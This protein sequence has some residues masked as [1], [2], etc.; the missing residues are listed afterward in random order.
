MDQNSRA[1]R[2][3]LTH[4]QWGPTS[5]ES[6]EIALLEASPQL[7][8]PETT[9]PKRFTHEELTVVLRLLRKNRAPGLDQLKAEA[10]LLLDYLGE[11]VLLDLLNNC[12]ST[13]TVPE[14]WKQALVVNIYKGK[15]SES[16]PANYRPISLLNVLYKIYASLLQKRLATA[17]DH[18]LRSSQFGFRTRR[19]TSDPAFI[20]RRLQDYSAKVGQQFH[21]LF[22]DWKQA[23]DKV[24]HSAMLIALR[25]LGVHPQ[26][27][28][29]IKDLYSDPTFCTQ[30]Y[31]GEMLGKSPHG[32]KTRMPPESLPIHNGN[33]SL[34]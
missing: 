7:H 34:I 15:G 28:S 14:E 10:I 23:F 22:L 2:D 11:V 3:H 8:P 25:R 13:C 17:H 9:S 4:V 19:S 1:I 33:D 26:Y 20:L 27:I 31:H 21:I 29:I 6:E 30:L 5:V 12:L 16:D 18:H 32:Y 24:D